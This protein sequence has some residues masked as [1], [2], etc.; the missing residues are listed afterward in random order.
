MVGR[1]SLLFA[2]YVL[3]STT[4]SILTTAQPAA[5]QPD[6]IF[7]EWDI[8]S[9]A[10]DPTA[11]VFYFFDQADS[12]IRAYS[13]EGAGRLEYSWEFS[14][15]FHSIVVDYRSRICVLLQ[16][17]SSFYI[18]QLDEQL[19]PLKLLQLDALSPARSTDGRPLRLLADYTNQ[20]WVGFFSSA[21]D[22][23][24]IDSSTGT[25]RSH[26]NLAVDSASYYVWTLDDSLN[27]WV[28]QSDQAQQTYGYDSS[29]TS[30]A[31]LSLNHTTAW[32]FSM[33]VSANGALIFAYANDETLVAFDVSG[34]RFPRAEW[35]NAY[36]DDLLTDLTWDSDG[37]LLARAM[38]AQSVLT[39]SRD[40][41]DLLRVWQSSVVSFARIHSLQYDEMSGDL[42]AFG[43]TEELGS[44]AL[45][46]VTSSNGT[47]VQQYNTLPAR[48]SGCSIQQV[49]LSNRGNLWHLLLCTAQVDGSYRRWH[50]LYVTDRS[51][52][53]KRQ[54]RLD[55][56]VDF[57]IYYQHFMV[58]EDQQL[59]YI[60][61]YYTIIKA[62]VLNV[63]AFNLT[64]VGSLPT[65]FSF[66]SL[67]MVE[68]SLN[69]RNNTVYFLTTTAN[70]I[71]CTLY[72]M[73]LTAPPTTD[74][75]F[76][77]QVASHTNQRSQYHI[78]Y[79][80]EDWS[81]VPRVLIGVRTFS[82]D[83]GVYEYDEEQQAVARYGWDGGAIDNIA[84]GSDGRLYGFSA[85]RRRIVSWRIG[86][87]GSEQKV[88]TVDS[89][90]VV[91]DGKAA[92]T[93]VA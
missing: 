34:Q 66:T 38:S 28:Q 81:T 68:M 67:L 11:P 60:P 90:S 45:Y 78:T 69:P 93:V 87:R 31:V 89:E 42:F 19:R 73:S 2:L 61:Y 24:A 23:Y 3:L 32:I 53:L 13:T 40:G 57:T 71:N 4:L 85:E 44:S 10:I 37:N 91:E 27:L 48:L 1:V 64:L 8:A 50:E 88:Q 76:T 6:V 59:L 79:T 84:A 26:F 83:G 21:I 63:Y 17:N 22:V 46:R 51:G 47:L 12:A 58:D 35:V 62:S 72:A 86:G 7:R 33:A 54:L 43:S 74:P 20:L 80:R 5:R 15:Y 56:K 55:G 30:I 75:L 25:Q 36:E 9:F 16:N 52:R 65:P 14:D 18:Q 92:V 70:W 41:R 49:E 82:G 29:G 77:F 39:V